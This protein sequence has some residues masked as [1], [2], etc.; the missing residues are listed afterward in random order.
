M[1]RFRVLGR[2]T[3]VLLL[4]LTAAPLAAVFASPAAGS[5]AMCASR[6]CCR[7]VPERGGGCRLSAPCG[8]GEPGV[9]TISP[10]TRAIMPEPLR[11]SEPESRLF[12][13]AASAAVRALR[14]ATV[15]ADPPPRL[16]AA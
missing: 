16:P 15:P 6:C 10:V 3:G 12:G 11:L 13:P 4:L 9:A 14:M 1:N 5:C 8:A 7:P 2:L